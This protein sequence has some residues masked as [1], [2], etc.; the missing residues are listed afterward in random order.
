MKIFRLLTLS[1]NTNSF[2]LRSAILVTQNG[3]VWKVLSSEPNC[4]KPDIGYKVHGY[5]FGSHGW[6]CA[7]PLPDPPP[8]EKKAILEQVWPDAEP[9]EPTPVRSLGPLNQKAARVREFAIDLMADLEADQHYD[10][11]SDLAQGCLFAHARTIV[12]QLSS[13]VRMIEKNRY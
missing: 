13:V 12:H 1:E 2:G 3:E 5:E 9:E 7:E 6:E 11:L 4:P 8:R 10:G